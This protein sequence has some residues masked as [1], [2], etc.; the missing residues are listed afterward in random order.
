MSNNFDD[1]V[2]IDN[3]IGTPAN[4]G[5]Y[6]GLGRAAGGVQSTGPR[7]Y[8]GVGDPSG[9][10]AAPA[11]T[12]WIDSSTGQVYQNMDGASAYQQS[13]TGGLYGATTTYLDA[14]NGND[15]T[16]GVGTGKPFKTMQ[17]A[18]DAI[19]A[20]FALA[21][22]PRNGYVLQV[23][24]FTQYDEDV[25]I[26]VTGG[27]HLTITSTGSFMIGA[28]DGATWTPTTTR[29]LILTGDA[30]A[31]S[32]IRPGIVIAPMVGQVPLLTTHMAYFGPRIS[33][34]I[35]FDGITGGNLEFAI[36]AEV[37]GNGGIDTVSNA[38]N[39]ILSVYIYKSRFRQA[40][41]WASNSNIFQI[42]QSRFDGLLTTGQ[43]SYVEGTRIIAGLTV[44]AGGSV[45]PVG[46]FNCDL[47]GTFTGPASAWIRLDL[48]SNT[49]FVANG[50]GP[51]AGGGS[52][53]LLNDATP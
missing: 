9:V 46:F 3:G 20:A 28:F 13:V 33:G 17:A 31:V 11:G 49:T 2:I 44:S 6:F 29:N 50:N 48:A 12:M 40:C 34:Q 15:A 51:I 43:V 37:Y 22:N 27:L 14:V 25:T 30:S 45:D 42:V 5:A 21:A 24:P 47:D 26:D 19:V 38:N 16:G 4:P 23:A 52:K 7:I 18:V 8:A 36:Q 39:R 53:T 32:G 35:N 1:P 10:M 41:N